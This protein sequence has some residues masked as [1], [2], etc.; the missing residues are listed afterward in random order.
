M[1]LLCLDFQ[2][3]QDLDASALTEVLLFVA[4]VCLELVVLF[5]DEITRHLCIFF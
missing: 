4:K 1:P 5:K 2:F 3:E